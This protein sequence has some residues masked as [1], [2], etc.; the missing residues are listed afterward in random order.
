[1]F[2]VNFLIA[3]LVTILHSRDEIFIIPDKI[4]I[5]NVMLNQIWYFLP[6]WLWDITSLLDLQD[7][8]SFLMQYF[9]CLFIDMSQSDG[10]FSSK[11]SD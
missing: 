5:S 8:V 7:C 6:V 3:L 11:W 4:H 2:I 1:M 10:W 9:V